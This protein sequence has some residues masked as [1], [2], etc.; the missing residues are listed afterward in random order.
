MISRILSWLA[1]GGIKAIGEQL[2]RAFQAKLDAKNNAERIEA[3]KQIAVLEARQAV[4][5]AE[6]G[7]WRTSWIRPAIAAPFAIF[8][9]KVVVWDKVLGRGV[10]DPLSDN[11]T[12]VMTAVIGAYFLTRPLE[13]R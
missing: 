12:W 8:I 9:W 1:G 13:K 4:L 5:I 7:S 6:Q 3:D 11:M 10:T 2:N